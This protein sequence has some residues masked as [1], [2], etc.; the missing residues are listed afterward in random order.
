MTEDTERP[1]RPEV[2]MMEGDEGEWELLI[3]SGDEIEL[4]IK[5]GRDV[6]VE[7]NPPLASVAVTDPEDIEQVTSGHDYAV[8]RA[9]VPDDADSTDD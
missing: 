8:F 2:S 3:Q 6:H 7:G 4:D 1:P 5:V 9:P